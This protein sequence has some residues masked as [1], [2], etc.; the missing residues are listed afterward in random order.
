MSPPSLSPSQGA[1]LGLQAKVALLDRGHIDSVVKQLMILLDN[2][3]EFQSQSRQLESDPDQQYKVKRKRRVG[4]FFII[5]QITD[6]LEKVAQLAPLL[7]LI[8]DLVS[9]SCDR[10]VTDSYTLTG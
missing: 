7:T 4:R 8:P 2:I 5:L 6:A 9:V 10:H 1:V 3:K